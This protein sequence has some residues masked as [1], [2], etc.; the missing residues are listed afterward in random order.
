MPIPTQV[1]MKRAFHRPGIQIAIVRLV[2]WYLDAA[3]RSKRWYVD[4]EEHLTIPRTG[5]SAIVAFWHEMLPLMPQLVGMS[6]RM[7]DY[8]HTPIH[9][10]VSRHADGKMIGATMERFQLLPVFGSSSRGGP[11]ALQTM[12]RLLRNGAVIGI[13]PDGPRGPARVA[14]PG[15]AQLAALAKVP[16]IPCAG[17]ISYGA[18]LSSWDRM[19][20]PLPLGHGV[21]VCR[22]PIL[23]SRSTWHEALPQIS[24][25][26]TQA[27][28]RA[29]LLCSG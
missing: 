6:R 26:M 25:E 24:A 7:P 21:I 15:V 23:V 14:A 20:M 2:G 17:A 13:T 10:L 5:G 18:R 9:F 3:L 12:V 8:V 27:A 22:P 19:I 11:A 1:S 16:V 29:E 28:I 4:G